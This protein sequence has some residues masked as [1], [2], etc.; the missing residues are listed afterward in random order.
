MSHRAPA[1]ALSLIALLG[2]GDPSL[3]AVDAAITID[4]QI[5][6]AQPIDAAGTDA[7]PTDAQP[8]DAR[9]S[10]RPPTPYEDMRQLGDDFLNIAHRCGGRLRPEET[11]E[12][13]AHAIEVGADVLEIDVHRTADGH[14]VCMHDNTVDR[15]TDGTGS[16]AE[17]SLQALQALDAGYRFSRDGGQTYPYRGQGMRVPTLAELLNT[18]PEQHFA[19]E[20]KQV[21][22]SIMPEVL[23]AIDAADARHRVVVASFG[24]EALVELRGLA[25]DL[26]TSFGLLEMLTFS[27]LTDE[28]EAEYQAPGRVLQV[29]PRQGGLEVLTPEILGRARRLGLK[30]QVW[31]INAADE[32]ARIH[33]LGVD[34]IMSDD[35]ARLNEVIE[36]GAQP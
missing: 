3:S 26:V 30:V 24:D 16:I 27:R 2:C 17:L 14:V 18:Y 1:W 22:P 5:S 29:P 25:P 13:C 31:T 15:T 35:P 6:D 23:A 12:A 7:Q 10:Q 9:P 8:T 11:I 36:R 4:A 28:T 21:R 32:M 19:I 34:G 33:G 20:V